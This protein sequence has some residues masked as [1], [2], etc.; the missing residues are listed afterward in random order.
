M[1]HSGASPLRPEAR[2]AIERAAATAGNPS[3]LHAVGRLAR[4]ELDIAV[5]AV[6]VLVATP[7]ADVVFT[8]SGAEANGLGIIGAARFRNGGVVLRAIPTRSQVSTM[9]ARPRI[10]VGR[11]ESESVLCAV[12]ALEAAGF[13][14]APLY[15]SELRDDVALI[16]LGFEEA[17]SGKPND[18]YAI[19][20]EAERLGI[21]LHVD[22]RRAAAVSPIDLVRSGATTMAIASETL[23]G[24]H[25]A[26]ALV[27]LKGSEL[28]PLW[29]GGGQEDGMRH[30]SQ[31][32]L[33]IAGFGA[34]A[35]AT[36]AARPAA[37]DLDRI[38]GG[39]EVA[40]SFVA[41]APR[42]AAT[43]A[44]LPNIS[45]VALESARADALVSLASDRGVMLRRVSIGVQA[46]AGWSTTHEDVEAA[47]LTLASCV[48]DLQKAPSVRR[49]A[50]TK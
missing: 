23:G 40:T 17:S 9:L 15:D 18:T 38:W 29:L 32:V 2:S 20:R 19:A 34:A 26:G 30:G 6:R 44:R 49:E 16:V 7:K 33:L 45:C 3:S 35:Q 42:S 21:P 10:L 46:T 31:A 37:N 24:P 48:R 5:D 36:V 13:V 11:D 27:K 28:T 25:G 8:G 47:R 39:L 22:A 1:D 41:T 14:R 50:N 12:S 43:D 4:R